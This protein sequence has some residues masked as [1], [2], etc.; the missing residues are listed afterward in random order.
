MSSI[1]SDESYIV[2]GCESANNNDGALRAYDK[3][4]LDEVR[5]INGSGDNKNLGQTVHI[6]SSTGVE[7]GFESHDIFY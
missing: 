3:K 1:D 4:T 5:L 2:I 6:H 7:T